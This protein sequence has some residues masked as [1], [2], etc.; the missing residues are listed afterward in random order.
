MYAII[1]IIRSPIQMA[2]AKQV[3]REYREHDSF[4]Q[5]RHLTEIFHQGR[6]KGESAQNAYG[7]ARIPRAYLFAGAI[8]ANGSTASRDPFHDKKQT[9]R[10]N[11]YI[12]AVFRLAGGV[13]PSLRLYAPRRRRRRRRRRRPY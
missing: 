5:T 9:D 11:L 8:Y 12:L 13:L 7:I 4:S 10:P 3:V 1:A 2:I 6:K